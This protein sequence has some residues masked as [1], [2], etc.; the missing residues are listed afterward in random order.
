[1]ATFRRSRSRSQGIWVYEHSRE[2]NL[3]RQWTTITIQES[4]PSWRCMI[5]TILECSQTFHGLNQQ[6]QG[7]T[8]DYSQIQ[9]WQPT[10]SITLI[11]GSGGIP[12]V[13]EGMFPEGWFQGTHSHISL[14]M[15]Y[16]LEWTWYDRNS[17][18]WIWQDIGIS[19][20]W[21]DSYLRPDGWWIPSDVDIGTH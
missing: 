1:M 20:A 19:V 10:R 18:D 17:I 4:I 16:S 8:S 9:V 3:C 13:P 15:A 21:N 12:I 11:L 2:E 5:I 14:G 7:S 6:I